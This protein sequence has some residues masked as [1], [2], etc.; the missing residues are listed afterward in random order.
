[1]RS[2][3]KGVTVILVFLLFIQ[4]SLF[5]TVWADDWVQTTQIDF[6]SGTKVNVDTLSDPGNVTLSQVWNKIPSTYVLDIGPPGSWDESLTWTPR[7]IFDGITY[8]MWYSGDDGTGSIGYANSTDGIT[9]TKHPSNPVLDPGSDAWEAQSLYVPTVLFDGVTYHMWYTGYSFG[10]IYRIGYANSSDGINW[11]KYSGNP[12]LDRGSSGSWD[13]ESIHSTSVIFDGSI[14][15]MW[16]AGENGSDYRIGYANSTDGLNWVKHPQNPILDMGSPGAW[17][18]GFIF[19]P[20]VHY[21]D[22]EM[23]YYIWY[24]GGSGPTRSLGY[25]TSE[26]GLNWTKYSEN[27]V[28]NVGSAGAWDDTVLT[29]P[30]VLYGNSTYHLWYTGFDGTYYRIGYATSSDGVNWTKIPSAPVVDLGPPGSWDDERCVYPFVMKDGTTYKMWYTGFDGSAARILYATSSDGIS[31][32]KNPNPVLD[33]GS[34]SSW[35]DEAVDSSVVIKDGGEY[36]MWYYAH[37]NAWRIGYANSTD[38]INWVKYPGNPILNLGPSSSWDDFAVAFPWVI[39]EGPLYKMWYGGRADAGGLTYRIGYAT[40]TDGLNWIKYPGNPVM[41]FG[42]PGEWDDNGVPDFSICFDDG[43]YKMHYTGWNGSIAKIGYATSEDGINWTR[44]SENPILDVGPS[45]SWDDEDVLYP[46]VIYDDDGINMWYTGSDGTYTRIGYAKITYKS[47]GNLISSIFDSGLGGTFWNVI[48]WT[49]SLSFGTNITIAVRN[50]DTSVP[51]ASWAPWST[52]MWNETGSSISLPRGRYI[53]YRATLTTTNQSVTP[54]L[55]EVNIN[56]TLNTALP[57]T[58]VSPQNDIMTTDNTPSFEWVFSDNEGDFQSGFSVQIDDDPSFTNVDY[59]SGIVN[60]G[61][62]LWTPSS[63]IADGTWYWCVRV[64]DSYDVWS[65]YS[66][67]WT[68]KI[69]TTPPWITDIRINPVPQEVYEIVNISANITDNFEV[70]EVWVNIS[71]EGNFTMLF[72]SK[73]GRYYFNQSYDSLGIFSY[74]IWANDT[75]NHWNYSMGSM[76]I[77][78]LIPPLIIEKVYPNPQEVFGFV[79]ISA[80]VTDNFQLYYVWIELVDPNGISQGMYLMHYSIVDL[81]YYWNRTYDIVGTYTFTIWANDTRNNWGTEIGSFVIE[82]LIPPIIS[83]VTDEPDPQE[84]FGNVNISADIVDNY[85]LNESSIE[86]YDPAGGFMGN[87]SLLPDPVTG[88]YYLNQ[89]YDILGTYM[90]TIWASDT[91]YNFDSVAG[92]FVIHDTTPPVITNISVVPNP[93]EVFFSVNISAAISDNYQLAGKWIEIYDPE[94]NIIGNF[95]MPYDIINMRYY[96]NQTYD[97]IG[98]YTFKILANDTSGNWAEVTDSFVILDSTPPV[99]DNIMDQPDPQEIFNSVNISCNVTDNYQ[100]SKVIV[101]IHDPDGDPIGNF[102]MIH[103]A[104]IGNFYWNQTYNNLGTYSF[105]IWTNDTS[106]NLASYQETFQIKTTFPPVIQNVAVKSDPPIV[107]GEVAILASITDEDTSPLDLTVRINITSMG[108]VPLGNFSMIYN[109]T[110]YKFK[111]SSDFD[112]TGTYSFEIWANDPDDNWASENG[113]FEI[114]PAKEPEEYNWKPVIALIF[115]VILLIIGLVVVYNR[116]MKFT[117]ELSK[118]RWYSFFFGVL[119]FACAEAITGIISFFTGLLAVPP[120]L[121]LGMIVDLTIL[122]IGLISI[123]TIYKKGKT[124]TDSDEDA[125]PIPVMAPYEELIAKPEDKEDELTL[126]KEE[127][128]IH[129]PPSPMEPPPPPPS[130]QVSFSLPLSFSLEWESSSEVSFCSEPPLSLYLSL[131]SEMTYCFIPL[132]FRIS[133]NNLRS[134]L[135]NSFKSERMPT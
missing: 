94:G 112:T 57:P 15:H 67:N 117:G 45:G 130:A 29:V 79:N 9:W 64:K 68:L 113:T 13:D 122:I 27:P 30:T 126:Q 118:D 115:T 39:K 43:I 41:D 3:S 114:E 105:T 60:S 69:D 31:W 92:L 4:I 129:S 75:S 80:N 102:S 76:N 38:G 93:Q 121:G 21:N 62:F 119:P 72:D 108:G 132:G 11:N 42:L 120:I 53:Q 22:T 35:D 26:D 7:I 1:M 14:Y 46:S 116:P 90:Y 52:E 123:I 17:D 95:S 91:S 125:E 65:E 44:Y 66:N 81:E 87:F 36:K 32:S 49:K 23:I 50:G 74:S 18:D 103:D 97:V 33:I 134:F 71:G 20:T 34:P 40:S 77:R 19:Y 73:S 104:I 89:S 107:G 25:A 59:S 78:D 51:D 83:N 84:I 37:G 96:W 127:I 110:E 6:D 98:T 128:P 5:Q 54:I 47:Y 63:S 55:S 133:N 10:D 2:R 101:E 8:H 99:I 100:L 24:I 131:S 82:D 58:L 111:Y 16:Y 61:S 85:M 88:R 135:V 28:L 48:N 86:I 109:S 70:D 106:G 56:Y 12:V 124:T